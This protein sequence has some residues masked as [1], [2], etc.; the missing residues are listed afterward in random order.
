M[1]KAG[2]RPGGADGAGLGTAFA[3]RRSEHARNGSRECLHVS[4]SGGPGRDFAIPSFV[5][6]YRPS[7]EPLKPSHRVNEAAMARLITLALYALLFARI[8]LQPRTGLSLPAH[9][10]KLELSAFVSSS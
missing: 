8:S 7:P 1:A 4:D 9:R 5:M 2:L 10:G 3:I 6:S